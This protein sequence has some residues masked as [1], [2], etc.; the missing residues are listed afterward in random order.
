MKR[1]FLAAALFALTLM[2]LS[3]AKAGEWIETD[4]YVAPLASISVDGDASDWAGIETLTDVKFRT[5]SDEWVVFEEYSGGIWNGPADQTVSVAFAWDPKALYVY[6][7][8]VDDEHEHKAAGFWD[9]DA[10]QLVF[11][12]AG[13]TTVTYLYNYALN[14]TQ[15]GIILGNEKVA[16][17]GMTT[18]DVVIVRDDS[19]KTT[20]YEAKFA[21]ELLGLA[22]FAAD[23]SIGIGVCVNDGDFD[24]PGQKGWGGWG[25]HAAVFGKDGDKTGLVTFS[26]AGPT[27]VEASSKLTTT[28][29]ELK[30]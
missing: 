10:V 16:G 18:D 20:F 30:H 7:Y 14:D 23:M 2:F 25:P 21:P 15:D 17:A 6:I 8:V 11:A 9:G 5:T 22:A 13:R 12:D 26:S 28:W 19:A 27:V 4:T 29:G 24:T 1:G 3:S